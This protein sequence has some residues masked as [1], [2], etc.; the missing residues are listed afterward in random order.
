MAASMRRY[1]FRAIVPVSAEK[2]RQLDDLL[3][4]IRGLLPEGVPLFDSDQYTDRSAR[5]LAAERIREKAYRLLG[6][7]LPY[8]IA[9]VIDRW[10]ESETQ[11]EI[12][13]TLVVDRESHKG[14]V[15]GR[16][17][18]KL[19]EISRLARIEIQDMLGKPVHLEVWVRVRKGWSDDPSALRKLGYG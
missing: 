18:A 14:I 8:G 12:V 1:P 10:D 5:F 15:I 4:E 7:E 3:K 2:H 13:A 19:R 11:A 6:D 17:G 16:E 9:V